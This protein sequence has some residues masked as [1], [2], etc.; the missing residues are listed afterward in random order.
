MNL[1]RCPFC[2]DHVSLSYSSYAHEYRVWHIHNNCMISDPFIIKGEHAKS[3]KEAAKIWNKR[4][5]V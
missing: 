5:S 2:G 4:V 3:L 1:E